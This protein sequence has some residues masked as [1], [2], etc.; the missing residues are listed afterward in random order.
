MFGHLQLRKGVENNPHHEAHEKSKS[1]PNNG[2]K[3]VEE[4]GS[5][6]KRAS[7]K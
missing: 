6:Q 3:H 1:G 5:P 7:T 4:S 2:P